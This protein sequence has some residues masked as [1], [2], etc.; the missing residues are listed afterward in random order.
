MLNLKKFKKKQIYLLFKLLFLF[1]ILLVVFALVFFNY[2][3]DRKIGQ[4]NNLNKNKNEE[5][6][7]VEKHLSYFYHNSENFLFEFNQSKTINTKNKS[8]NLKKIKTNLYF[9]KVIG[10]SSA[11]LEID[12]NNLY[13]VSATGIFFSIKK[14][15]LFKK[16]YNPKKIETNINQLIKNENFFLKSY[17]GIKDVLI[18][19]NFIF[20]SYVNEKDE[21]C[22]NTGVLKAKLDS[23]FLEFEKFFDHKECKSLKKS[24][25][26]TFKMGQ[27]GGRII[28][29]KSNFLLTHGSYSEFDD[30]QNDNSIFGK[31]LLI[32]SEGRILKNF[33]KGHRNPQ[34]LSL[35]NGEVIIETE[36]GP[37][38]GDEIN[39]INEDYNYGWPIASY[40]SHYEGQKHMDKIYPLPNSHLN[41]TEPAMY[42]DKAIAISEIISVPGKFNNEIDRS[43]YLASM[44]V[45]NDYGDKINLFHLKFNKKDLY[46][47]DIIPI[48]ERIRDLIYD[49]DKNEILMFLDTSATIGILSVN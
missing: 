45:N 42:F 44:K 30:V 47:K 43:I 19:N 6:K 22:F 35:I 24:K 34:G 41:F 40:G 27:A 8:Y 5:I 4:Y 38:G 17:A 26:K 49:E 21:N 18:H 2:Y 14:N 32:D 33:S 46:I 29:Y 48:G 12:K 16:A 1:N 25:Y 31:I 39:I 15:E 11:Y 3:K 23:N 28:S 20:V 37:S 13:V 7:K 9:S 36:H 10:Q